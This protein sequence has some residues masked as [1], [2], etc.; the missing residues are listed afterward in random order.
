MF[1]NR[2]ALAAPTF[3][4]PGFTETS[5]DSVIFFGP[6]SEPHA[7]PRRAMNDMAFFTRYLMGWLDGIRHRIE[8]DRRSAKV[9]EGEDLAKP[10]PEGLSSRGYAQ[11]TAS[12][13]FPV[14]NRH[15]AEGTSAR[16]RLPDL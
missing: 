8:S 3:S 16:F 11:G 2:S 6:L 12:A 7:A 13:G 14:G 15:E 9:K 1:P 5:R 10:A 4:S